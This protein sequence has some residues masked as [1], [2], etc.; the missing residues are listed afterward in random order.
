M[1]IEIKHPAFKSKRCTRRACSAW[2]IGLDIGLARSATVG[3]EGEDG[4][5]FDATQYR[6]EPAERRTWVSGPR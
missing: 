2:T 4:C 3:V 6:G 1:R 5:I